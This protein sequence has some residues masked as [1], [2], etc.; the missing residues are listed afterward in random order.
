MGADV[1]A[2]PIVLVRKENDPRLILI[3]DV[4]DDFDAGVPVGGFGLAG[5]GVDLFEPVR[6][7]GDQAEADVFAR[8]LKFLEPRGLTVLFAAERHG[9]IEEIH[10]GFAHDPNGQGAHYALVIGVRGKEEG[11]GHAFGYL[12][13]SCWLEAAEGIR[14]GFADKAGV[15]GDELDVGVH[16]NS[17]RLAA[18]TAW[19]WRLSF[20]FGTWKVIFGANS[21][22]STFKTSSAP[23]MMTLAPAPEVTRPRSRIF[24]NS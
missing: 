19:P 12:R 2:V 16:F 23:A 18:A 22:N 6:A 5:F 21:G 24:S 9:D 14:F 17:G 13:P 1:R 4:Q 20:S 11:F 8:G 3:E 7:G 10:F 15:I